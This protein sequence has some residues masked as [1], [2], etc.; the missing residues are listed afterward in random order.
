[1]FEIGKRFTF[2]AAHQLDHLPDWHKCHRLHGHNYVVEIA[3]SDADGFG[4][5]ERGFV[6]DY[7]ELQPFEDYIKDYF[8]HRN[9]NDVM[10]Q[11][12][13]TTAENLAKHFYEKAVTLFADVRSVTVK[14]TEKTWATYRP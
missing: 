4:L 11:S 9:L 7:A 14:E 13:L 6:I 8:D 1:M 10:G 3:V 2:A 12:R 5:D